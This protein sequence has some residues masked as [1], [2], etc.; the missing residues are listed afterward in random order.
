AR[1]FDRFQQ[2]SRSESRDQEG[3]GIGLALARDLVELHGGSICVASKPGEG[4]AFTVCLPTGRAHLSDDQIVESEEHQARTDRNRIHNELSILQEGN[5]ASGETSASPPADD[6][7]ELV[8]V[9]DDNPDVR[10]YVRDCLA[11]LYRVVEAGD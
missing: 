5:D 7:R 8:L 6:D 10:R 3:T 2:A 9:V 1:I 4:S 11:T